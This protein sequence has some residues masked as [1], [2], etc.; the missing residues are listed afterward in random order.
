[1]LN[2]IHD[3]VNMLIQNALVIRVP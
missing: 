3:I 2:E 1:M